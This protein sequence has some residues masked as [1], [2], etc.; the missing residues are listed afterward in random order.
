MD[1]N[2][3]CHLVTESSENTEVPLNWNIA[4][5]SICCNNVGVVNVTSS[6]VALQPLDVKTGAQGLG[7]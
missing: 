2:V 6:K 1:T 4:F 5:K 3:I 7:H